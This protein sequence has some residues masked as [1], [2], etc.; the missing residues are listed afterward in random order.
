[1]GWV[2]YGIKWSGIIIL[3]VAG[4]FCMGGHRS[5]QQADGRI[6][7]PQALRPYLNN[8]EFIEKQNV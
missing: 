2:S 6:L 1:M 7:I 8:Q 3:L 4:G 5:Y